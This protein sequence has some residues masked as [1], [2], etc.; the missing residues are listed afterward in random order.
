[1]TWK[2]KTKSEFNQLLSL[3][4]SLRLVGWDTFHISFIKNP[5]RIVWDVKEITDSLGFHSTSTLHC[6]RVIA[7][8]T[9]ML[10]RMTWNNTRSFLGKHERG[11]KTES[12][13]KSHGGMSSIK[14]NLF[15]P[16]FLFSSL[17]PPL[18]LLSLCQQRYIDLVECERTH[19]NVKQ[20][21][22]ARHL[23]PRRHPLYPPPRVKNMCILSRPKKKLRIYVRRIDW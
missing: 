5:S 20:Q 22:R 18:L 9:P 15:F 16:S 3:S 10:F 21:Q 11:M 4:H 19:K 14:N 7:E 23:E 13:R 1:M 6:L 8:I 12:Q 2:S 17:S